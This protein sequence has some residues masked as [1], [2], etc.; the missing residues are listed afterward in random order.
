MPAGPISANED[1]DGDGQ[2]FSVGGVMDVGNEDRLEVV[3][4]RDAAAEAAPCTHYN[5][6]MVCAPSS[7]SFSFCLLFPTLFPD[8]SGDFHQPRLHKVELGDF[9]KHL[10]FRSSRFAQHRRFPWFA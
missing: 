3:Q 7:F 8:S 5:Q 10:R 2:G 4:L 9:F 1:N 6:T